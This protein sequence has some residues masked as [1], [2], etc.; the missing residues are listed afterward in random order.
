MLEHLNSEEEYK[1]AAQ[2]IRKIAKDNNIFL[3]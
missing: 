3:Q 2:H 1:L